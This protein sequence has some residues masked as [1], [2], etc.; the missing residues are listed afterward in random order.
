ME[1]AYRGLLSW[2]RASCWCWWVWYHACYGSDGHGV[3]CSGWK[4]HGHWLFCPA[5]RPTRPE[6]TQVS[7]KSRGLASC[8]RHTPSPATPPQA[9]GKKA[10]RRPFHTPFVPPV[11]KSTSQRAV[12][13][14]II[15]HGSSKWCK[16]KQCYPKPRGFHRRFPKKTIKSSKRRNSFQVWLQKTKGKKNTNGLFLL[17]FTLDDHEPPPKKPQKNPKEAYLQREGGQAQSS[18]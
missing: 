15:I 9:W 7:T 8:L 13:M 10:R 14:S 12:P 5:P 2:G 4:T 6:I 17:A 11:G 1:R 3:W 18:R 16:R